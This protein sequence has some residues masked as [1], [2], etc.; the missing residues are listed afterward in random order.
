MET[1]AV[2]TLS[3]CKGHITSVLVGSSI[4]L[5]GAGLAKKHSGFDWTPVAHF[6]DGACEEG[7]LHESLNMASVKEFQYYF[8][9]RIMAIHARQA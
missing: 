3:P 6:G 4:P 2:C 8:C 1:W 5:L 9:A 7:I